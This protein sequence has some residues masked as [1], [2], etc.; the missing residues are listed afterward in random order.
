MVSALS[1]DYSI[2]LITTKEELKLV[3][4]LRVE[5][6]VDEQGFSMEDEMDEYDAFSALFMLY[7]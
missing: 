3:H 1:S 7:T 2:V 5:V 6:F 4:S